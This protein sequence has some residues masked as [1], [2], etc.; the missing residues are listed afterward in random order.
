LNT[1]WWNK[2][3]EGDTTNIFWTVLPKAAG[4]LQCCT[5]GLTVSNRYYSVS[6]KQIKI[7]FIDMFHML[8]Y[9]HVEWCLLG[10]YAVKTSNLTYM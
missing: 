6:S 5:K 9:L 8:K 3:L 2:W 7:L 10:C 4:E 1:S